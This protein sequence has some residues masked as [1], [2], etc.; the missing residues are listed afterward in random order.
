MS[1]LDKQDRLDARKDEN[2][3]DQTK[4]T[5]GMVKMVSLLTSIDQVGSWD[6]AYDQHLFKNFSEVKKIK[7]N[8][9]DSLDDSLPEGEIPF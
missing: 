6:S 8:D 7:H 2:L 3:K 1:C 4:S 9:L 5:A